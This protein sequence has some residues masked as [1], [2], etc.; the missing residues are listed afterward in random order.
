MPTFTIPKTLLRITLFA[1]ALAWSAL[2][3]V[4]TLATMDV[5]GIRL[6]LGVTIPFLIAVVLSILALEIER[7]PRLYPAASVAALLAA[8]TLGRIGYRL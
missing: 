5:G 8:A 6:L 4:G 2:T 3:L 7:R 1:E